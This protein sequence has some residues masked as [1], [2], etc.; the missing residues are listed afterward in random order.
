MALGMEF[1]ENGL[2]DLFVPRLGGA[3][4]VVIGQLKLICKGRTDSGQIIAISLRGATLGNGGLLH[5][6]TMLVEAGEKECFLAHAAA[7]ACDDVGNDLFVGMAQV[8]L[9]VDVINGGGDVK[10]F[11]HLPLLGGTWLSLCTLSAF[12]FCNAFGSCKVR[13]VQSVI[14]SVERMAAK[15]L[16]FFRRDL[17]ET[18]A[19]R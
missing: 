16:A 11:I 17:K 5:L 18:L 10:T 4:K 8:W 6:L 15:T 9:T 12:G 14:T 13:G 7:R 19:S 3:D 2:H 1:R